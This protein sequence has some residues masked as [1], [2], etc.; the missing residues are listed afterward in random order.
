MY[1]QKH[2]H[3]D[4]Y[5]PK[6]HNAVLEYTFISDTFWQPPC[7]DTIAAVKIL[8]CRNTVEISYTKI[9]QE[10]TLH[11]E[12][13]ALGKGNVPSGSQSFIAKADNPFYCYSYGGYGLYSE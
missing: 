11:A 6:S 1:T 9:E 12:G 8:Q 3:T 2:T 5:R 7:K 4:Q 13:Q 10:L